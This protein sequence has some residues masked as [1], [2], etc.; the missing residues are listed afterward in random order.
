MIGFVKHGSWQFRSE[1]LY[2]AYPGL[3]ILPYSSESFRLPPILGPSKYHYNTIQSVGYCICITYI[4]M[5][6]IFN[7]Y[8]M[9][10]N[11][12]VS[13]GVLLCIPRPIYVAIQSYYAHHYNTFQSVAYWIHIIFIFR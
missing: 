13:W 2:Y 3:F 11:D 1:L 9:S 5:V 7:Q 10:I 4:H 6:F 12:V 8:L